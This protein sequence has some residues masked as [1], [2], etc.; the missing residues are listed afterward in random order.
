MLTA[1]EIPAIRHDATPR[2]ARTKPGGGPAERGPAVITVTIRHNVATDAQGQPAGMLNGY[3][4]GDP[5][6]RVFTYQA[7]RLGS[8]E[9]VAEEAF[10]IC[11]G[12][13]CDTDGEDPARRYYERVLR[14]LSLPSE[15]SGVACPVP[16]LA[17]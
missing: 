9:A 2:T 15:S 6:V 16:K 1:T 8:P 11:N 14:S 3:Q 5:V 17:H 13:P 4:A 10:A 7:A 12:H